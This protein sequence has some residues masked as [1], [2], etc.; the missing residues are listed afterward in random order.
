MRTGRP[1]LV[2]A[3]TSFVSAWHTT[4]AKHAGV[5]I[6]PEQVVRQVRS[7]ALSVSVVT[8]AELRAGHLKARWGMRRRLEAEQG[9]RQFKQRAVDRSVAEAW[10]VLKEATRRSGRAC[11][12]NDLWIAA[13]GF[14]R[15]MPVLTCDRDFRALRAAGVKVVYLPRRPG[16]AASAPD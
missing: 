12:D 15:G 3:D 14:A 8:V 6:W 11:S 1:A 5:D 16:A 7:G 10:A 4:A 13:T 2:V 9:L